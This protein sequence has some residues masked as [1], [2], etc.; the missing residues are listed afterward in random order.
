VVMSR[1]VSVNPLLVLVSILVGAS[2]GDW[3]GGTFGA[4]VAALISIPAAG[5]VQVVV[6]EL[7]R[8]TA[9]VVPDATPPPG[10][11]STIAPPA[12]SSTTAPL[13]APTPGPA[14]SPEPDR[15]A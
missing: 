9:P 6:R 12:A 1:T 11:P 4:F 14:E 2:I 10:P 3:L 15:P 7:W 8:A 13:A 5:A